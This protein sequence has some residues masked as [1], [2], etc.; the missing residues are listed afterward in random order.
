MCLLQIWRSTY[1]LKYISN[2]LAALKKILIP[3]NCICNLV[4]NQKIWLCPFPDTLHFSFDILVW[5]GSWPAGSCVVAAIDKYTRT[6]ES[7]GGKG[8]AHP[9]SQEESSSTLA[10]TG[11]FAFLSPVHWGGSSFTLHRFALGGYRKQRRGCC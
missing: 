9:L 8:T 4:E 11:F 3:A 5:C 2:H 6:T 10:L 7:C 1:F